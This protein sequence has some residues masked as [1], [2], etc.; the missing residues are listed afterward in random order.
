MPKLVNIWAEDGTLWQISLK[1]LK[2]H[3][4]LIIE[5]NMVYG[6]KHPGSYTL[7]E[8]EAYERNA[9]R[10]LRKLLAAISQNP[11][12]V[13]KLDQMTERYVICEDGQ[14]SAPTK[15]LQRTG[16]PE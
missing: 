2:E 12:V 7:A 4:E 14:T 5:D 10:E 3:E 9:R 16:K 11:D 6:L 1:E 15:I 13:L 8:V